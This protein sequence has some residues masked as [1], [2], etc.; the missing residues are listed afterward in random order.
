MI[1]KKQV[2]D[3]KTEFDKEN[4]ASQPEQLT[5]KEQAYRFLGLA[6]KDFEQGFQMIA[7]SLNRFRWHLKIS[8]NYR[9]QSCLDFVSGTAQQ[10][11]RMSLVNPD[12]GLNW[13]NVKL[14]R[15][16]SADAKK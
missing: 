4:H 14:S 10:L 7:L 16:G 5:E 12:C 8:A 1:N 6:T 15:R 2:F 9:L 3:L 13:P 11:M